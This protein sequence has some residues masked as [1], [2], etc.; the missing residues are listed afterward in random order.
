MKRLK[1]NLMRSGLTAAT[2][3]LY[4]VRRVMQAWYEY[5]IGVERAV[6]DIRRSV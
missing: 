6:D 5:V 2:Y 4:L 3:V 1:R